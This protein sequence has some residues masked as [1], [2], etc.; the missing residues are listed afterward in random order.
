[1]TLLIKTRIDIIQNLAYELETQK[2][3]AAKLITQEMGKPITESLQEVE[4]CIAICR[5][6]TDHVAQWLT[7]QKLTE[8]DTV[9]FEP[10]GL[11]LGIMP[12]NFPMWQIFRFI[13]PTLMAG[14]KVLIKPAPNTPKCSHFIESLFKSDLYK[15]IE[16]DIPQTEAL[17]AD[18]SI[19]GVS[20]TGSVSAGMRVGE[21]AGRH[22]KPC[23]LELGGSDPFIICENAHL[24]SATSAAIRARL[25]NNGQTCIAAKRF[26]I[27]KNIFQ[28]FCNLYL[29]K[30]ATKKIGDPSKPETELGPL[31]RQ[32]IKDTLIK[33][34]KESMAQGAKKHT[35]HPPQ[36]GRFFEPT[37]LTEI[38]TKMPVF[39]EETF[40]PVAIAMPFT[41]REE[42]ITLANLTPYGLGASIWTN[43]IEEA[44]FIAS[45]IDAGNIAINK[46]VSSQLHLPFGGTK[47]SGI[48]RELG[49]Y[50]LTNFCN[51]KTV[52]C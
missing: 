36:E 48:G 44:Q 47:N 25:L 7:P 51:I 39:T 35:T 15:T 14:N 17:I 24:E 10:L 9:Y 6:Y 50:G 19:K 42:A 40:G 27:H 26:L 18:P 37:L 3:A 45:Q 32:D 23:I 16:C 52:S 20:L 43:S 30:M 22:L 38:N 11:I 33:Q 21:L 49:S 2:I 13:I 1:M 34:V 31:A 46:T 4:K 12:W 28:D 41:T 8:N 29:K 5:F